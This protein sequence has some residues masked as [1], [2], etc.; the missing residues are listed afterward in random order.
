M[1]GPEG[2]AELARSWLAER[3]PARLRI[4]EARYSTDD[5]DVTLPDPAH[6][7]AHEV[8][9]IGIEDW[10][11]VYVLP[12]RMTGM[13]AVDVRED[14]SEVYRVTYSVRALGWL[15][16][17]DY[18]TTDQLRKRY[19]L[20]IREALLERKTLTPAETY[21]SGDYGTNE[22]TVV[23]P[24]SIREDYS[25]V[26]TDQAKRTIAGV[27]VDFNLIVVETLDGPAPLGTLLEPVEVQETG[28]TAAIPPHP[29]L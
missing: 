4:L 11:S 22:D 7:L 26:F 3:I 24:F 21:G 27:L 18:A 29:A 9:P 10:P 5:V 12:Q 1:L 8:G 20:A 2:A 6:V 16:A 19:A 15:R 14:A 23:D 28:D 13:T 25:E 17:Q